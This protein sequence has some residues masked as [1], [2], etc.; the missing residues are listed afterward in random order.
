[1]CIYQTGLGN[2]PGNTTPTSLQSIFAVFGQIESVR[3]LSHKNCGF[4]N[5]ESV[6]SAVK[7]RDALMA[8]EIGAQGFTGARVGFAKIPPHSA[9]TTAAKPETEDSDHYR[10][11]TAAAVSSAVNAQS[12]AV[13]NGSNLMQDAT[14]AWQNDLFNIMCQFN[15]NDAVARNFVKGRILKLVYLCMRSLNGFFV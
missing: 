11:Q 15:M 9:T 1:M 10:H 8:N 2:I 3:V 13:E 6:N 12:S 14:I 7:A 4:I 5:F